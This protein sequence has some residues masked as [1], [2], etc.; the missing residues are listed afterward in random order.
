MAEI[1]IEEN[2]RKLQVMD[3][4]MGIK[5]KTLRKLDLEM[6]K[7]KREVII[8]VHTVTMTVTRC[9]ND[10][11]F[12]SLPSSKLRSDDSCGFLSTVAICCSLCAIYVIWKDC[13]QDAVYKASLG[14]LSF[15]R[16][17]I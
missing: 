8:S 2:K 15:F 11:Y 17:A 13:K 6:Q 4:E 1:K 14:A 9:M 10:N 16:L 5:H 7:L 12:F 3:V